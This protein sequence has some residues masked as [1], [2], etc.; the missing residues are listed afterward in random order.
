[1]DQETVINYVVGIVVVAALIV[2]LLSM[3]FGKVVEAYDWLRA[4]WADGIERQR[5]RYEARAPRYGLRDTSDFDPLGDDEPEPL[6]SSTFPLLN[7]A[8]PQAN[9]SMNPAELQLNASEI[10]GLQRMIEHNKTAAKPSKS[11]T[12]QAG[13]GV[14][15][16]GSAAYARAS[17]IYDTFF[18]PPA[19][20]VK[21]RAITPEQEAVRKSLGLS[22]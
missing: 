3:L 12:I 21:Y 13:F 8:E 7:G 10:A 1:M 18:G 15:R 2:G 6:S 20:A 9:G 14:S 22:K 19:P 5:V 17:M 4:W 16:G 11:S